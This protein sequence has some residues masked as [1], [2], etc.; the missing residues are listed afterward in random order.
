M[1]KLVVVLIAFCMCAFV[2]PIS[3]QVAGA[4]VS[5]DCGETTHVPIDPIGN[6]NYTFECTISL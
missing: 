1:N 4:A 6:L 3:A 2:S 5:L